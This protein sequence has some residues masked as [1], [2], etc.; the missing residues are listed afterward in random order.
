M[1]LKSTSEGTANQPLVK[2]K[3]YKIVDV[4]L[5]SVSKPCPL[6]DFRNTI[7]TKSPRYTYLVIWDDDFDL[8]KYRWDYIQTRMLAGHKVII[9]GVEYNVRYYWNDYFE[10]ND[11]WLTAIRRNK[12]LDILL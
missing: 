12:L 7:I 11:R 6:F 3:E 1:V 2:G 10:P 8:E 4:T 5:A 9:E